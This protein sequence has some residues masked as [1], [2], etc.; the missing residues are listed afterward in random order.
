MKRSKRAEGDAGDQG[1]EG[2]GQDQALLAVLELS[3]AV[4]DRED[5]DA[6]HHEAGAEAALKRVGQHDDR[7]GDADQQEKVAE[8]DEQ[9][10]R[11]IYRR[12]AMVNKLIGWLSAG[13]LLGLMA[14]SLL[15]PGYLGWDNT[16]A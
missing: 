4:I 10:S 2:S 5:G 9:H 13:A 3:E 14:A 1:T 8:D 6:E 15:A 16:A 12:M 11:G 7:A